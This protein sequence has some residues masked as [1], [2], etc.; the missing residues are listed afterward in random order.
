M[1][2]SLEIG[3]LCPL[4]PIVLGIGLASIAWE[5]GPSQLDCWAVDDPVVQQEKPLTVKADKASHN[6][7]RDQL[8]AIVKHL[9]E[10]IGERNLGHRKQLDEAADYLQREFE[11]MGYAVERQTYE[12]QGHACHNLIA[13]IK[14][15]EKP[16]EVLIVG[17]HYDSASDSPGANDNASGVA[18]MAVIADR[19][20]R[21]KPKRTLRFV[22]FTNEEPPY[23]QRE[24]RM[25]SWVYARECKRKME[26]L[27]GVISLET[28]GYYCDEANSQKYPALIA[29]RYP[30]TGNFIGFVSDLNSRPFLKTVV[31]AFRKHSLFP[32]EEAFLPG[33]IQGVGWSDHWS[34]WQEGYRGLMVTDTAPF[35]YPHY[36][37]P[38]DTLDKL[39]FD[40]LSDVVT[41]LTKVV[42]ELVT[43]S[44]D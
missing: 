7:T 37:L 8:H 31:D 36:H 5:R 25:G 15:I 22:A 39:D 44:G 6:A 43:R 35:R 40:R 38:T 23:F 10:S 11:K 28:M 27:L 29:S 17:A 13:E 24:G 21:L 19:L 30:T 3:R 12:V 41:G 4:M 32:S 18:S 9:S 20:S 26:A 42:E 14:G 2:R 33:E 16:E 34:F 1:S